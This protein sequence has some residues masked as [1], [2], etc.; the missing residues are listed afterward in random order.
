[1]LAGCSLGPAGEVKLSVDVAAIKAA[2]TQS[3]PRTDPGTGLEISRVRLLVDHAKIGYTGGGAS[4][5]D[6]DVG[7]T[8]V[9]LSADEIA[10]GAH[11][12]FNLGT[13]ASGTYG[14]AEIEIEPLDADADASD[15]VF[16]DFRATKASVLVDGAYNGKTFQ[17]AGHFLA[18]QGTDGK[19]TV[20]ASAPV[21]LAM[22]VDPSKWFLDANGVATDPTD[23]AQHDTLALAVCKTLDTQPQLAAPAGGGPRAHGGGGGG[24][25][26][27]CVEQAQ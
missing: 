10:N 25:E 2:T 8:V 21:T 18:E 3:D 22:S 16:D 27:H 15:A 26:V 11:R 17:F 19:V 23:A 7:P 24:G 13:L 14:G 9:D 4:G 12:E 1:M 5:P 6:A 20:D